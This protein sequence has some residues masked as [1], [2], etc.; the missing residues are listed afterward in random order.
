MVF[1]RI[2]AYTGAAVTLVLCVEVQR[3]AFCHDSGSPVRKNQVDP[4]LWN[5]RKQYS[6]TLQGLQTGVFHRGNSL[7][8]NEPLHGASEE[9][10][11]RK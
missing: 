6:G 7:S 9:G 1:G 3:M 2:R 4:W 10:A 11:W 5:N 8:G